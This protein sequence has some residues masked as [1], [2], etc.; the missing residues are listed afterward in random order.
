MCVGCKWSQQTE[1]RRQEGAANCLCIQEQHVCEGVTAGR[2][3]CFI[4]HRM[5][6]QFGVMAARRRILTMIRPP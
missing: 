2:L 4:L 5:W 1:L 6:Q 3:F